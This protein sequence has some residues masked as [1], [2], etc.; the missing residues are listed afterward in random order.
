MY[1]DTEFAGGRKKVPR[2]S[3]LKSSAALVAGGSATAV[4]TALG[5]RA[6]DRENPVKQNLDGQQVLQTVEAEYQADPSKDENFIRVKSKET[7]L[8]DNELTLSFLP[9]GTKIRAIQ[10]YGPVYPSAFSLGRFPGPDGE[11]YGTWYKAEVPVYKREDDKLVPILNDDK[12]PVLKTGYII[13]NDLVRIKAF[14][15]QTGH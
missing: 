12:T 6:Y 15:T 2:R 4:L 14:D 13:G 9:K 5:L 10:V 1:R 11:S 3:F 7:T 8:D